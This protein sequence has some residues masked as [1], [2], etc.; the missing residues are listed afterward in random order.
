MCPDV[1][2]LSIYRDEELPS[3]WKEKLE[4]HLN[5]C[6]CCRKK[7]DAF[8]KLTEKP[9][10]DEQEI[11]ESVKNRVWRNLQS[12]K[13]FQPRIVK[14]D[15]SSN[16]SRIWQKKL[17]I[18]LPAAA[19]AAVIIT[20][21][22]VMWLRGGENNN[23]GFAQ[24]QNPYDRTGFML[25]AEDDDIPG[26]M[27]VSDINGVLQYLDSSGSEIIILRLPENKSFSRTGEPAILR[28]A[29]FQQSELGDGSRNRG[30]RSRRQ[31]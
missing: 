14:N 2:I 9:A 18:P 15:N 21:I 26:I 8:G 12:R 29:D 4:S 22:T 1:Q 19:A 7:L 3:P 25:A 16:S 6:S 20:L 11:I 23:S 28:A 13:Q 27:P 5:E 17:S 30:T 10:S 24:Q 31:Q